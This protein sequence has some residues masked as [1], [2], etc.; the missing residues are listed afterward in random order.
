M[1]VNLLILMT[2]RD[3]MYRLRMSVARKRIYN[4]AM[5]SMM[6]H[7]GEDS[8][9]SG[10]SV[11]SSCHGEQ[12]KEK[13]DKEEEKLKEDEEEEEEE[14]NESGND[15]DILEEIPDEVCVDIIRVYSCS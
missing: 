10:V 1:R 11:I 6:E 7:R 12:E 14:E 13:K 9:M 3:I 15:T 2:D 5:R 4:A 8:N